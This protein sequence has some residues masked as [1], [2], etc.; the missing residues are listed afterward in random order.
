MP[1]LLF[2]LNGMTDPE[3]LLECAL[4]WRALKDVYGKDIHPLPSRHLPNHGD[5]VFGLPTDGQ[6]RAAQNELG[7]DYWDIPAFRKRV[8]RSFA[9]CN[10]EEATLE[11]ERLGRAGKDI[12]V[13]SVRQKEFIG[14]G[15]AGQSLAS[16]LGDMVY[17]YIDYDHPVLMIQEK[18][19]MT[20]EYRC[21]VV[22]GRVVTSSPVLAS[23][24]P[25]LAHSPDLRGMNPEDMLYETPGADIGAFSQAAG[26]AEEMRDMAG[27]IARE[28][29]LLSGTIDL[30]VVN[31]GDVEP[32]EI[33]I[34]WPGSYGLYFCDPA[35]I[36]EASREIVP[37]ALLSGKL[38]NPLTQLDQAPAAPSH[39]LSADMISF[40]DEI[41][42][43][44]LDP[45]ENWADSDCGM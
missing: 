12:F 40:V 43:S 38:E 9:A 7:R 18:V 44:D 35:A 32:I 3:E 13:K 26:L 19:R 41:R 37:E 27:D 28:C 23:A 42:E 45:E 4:M 20:H 11:V 33:N 5:L 39:R 6:R 22:A 34:G 10:L 15:R 29:G 25:N 14:T 21:V 30:A 36:A 17:S 31:G 24:T 8:R 16:I 1:N 2:A